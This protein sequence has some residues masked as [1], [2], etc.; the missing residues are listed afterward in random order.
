MNDSLI[1]LINVS[2]TIKDKVVLDNI[3]LGI[4]KGKTYGFIGPNG[5]GKTMLFRAI[6]G[7]VNISSGKIEEPK[8]INKGS[9]IGTS[10]FFPKYT[11]FTNLKLLAG[12]K[13]GISDNEIRDSMLRVGLDYDDTKKIRNYSV[14]MMQKLAIAQAVMEN[15]QLLILDEPTNDL[16]RES[17]KCIRKLILQEKQRETTILIASHNTEDI[18]IL[19]DHVYR[20]ENGKLKPDEVL[21][22]IR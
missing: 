8:E 17:I 20:M 7:F 18:D 9:N 3:D 21:A 2:K 16:D 22:R 1:S 5:S 4:V 6:L 14:E 11:G 10:G 19:C 12:I 15:P 13:G